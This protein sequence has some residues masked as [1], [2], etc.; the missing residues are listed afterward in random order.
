MIRL[1]I[2]GMRR[3]SLDS[4]DPRAVAGAN[5]E[6]T[7]PARKHFGDGNRPARGHEG[8]RAA[9]EARASEPGAVR[10]FV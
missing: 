8:D 1:K 4:F 9:A 7:V 3:S 2:V 10:A 6:G 5:P